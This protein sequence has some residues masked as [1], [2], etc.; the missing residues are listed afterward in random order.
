M[1]KEACGVENLVGFKNHAKVVG[2]RDDGVAQG[3]RDATI[4]S[5]GPVMRLV[6]AE[7]HVVTLCLVMA[8]KHEHSFFYQVLDHV[9][10]VFAP[11]ES[12]HGTLFFRLT[13]NRVWLSPFGRLVSF[14]KMNW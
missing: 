11:I 1:G 5:V 8:P 10:T 14:L 12:P 9:S 7:D 4:A 6:V 13:P 2:F 3:R